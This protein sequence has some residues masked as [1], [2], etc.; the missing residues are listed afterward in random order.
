MTAHEAGC[1]ELA[2]RPGGAAPSKCAMKPLYRDPSLT[3]RAGRLCV[4]GLWSEGGELAG[5]SLRRESDFFSG[6]LASQS[7]STVRHF[8]IGHVPGRTAEFFATQYLIPK[9]SL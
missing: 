4:S 8:L 7:A 6:Q 1:I 3:E 5:S 2:L 9:V